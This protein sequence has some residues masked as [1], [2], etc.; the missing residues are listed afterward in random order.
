ME[1]Y[2]YSALDEDGWSAPRPVRIT[3]VEMTRCPLC[4]SLGGLQGRSARLR[5]VSPPPG[6]DPWIVQP[7]ASRYTD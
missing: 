3:P 7:V 1:V 4:T 2:L 6:F 5:T